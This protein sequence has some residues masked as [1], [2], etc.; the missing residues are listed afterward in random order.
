MVA[1]PNG[2]DKLE[3]VKCCYL[4]TVTSRG[5]F[6]FG[7]LDFQCWHVSVPYAF[8]FTG[9]VVYASVLTEIQYE[10]VGIYALYLWRSSF[11]YRSPIFATAIFIITNI[12]FGWI[13]SYPKTRCRINLTDH[14][15]HFSRTC[16]VR[17]SY[18]PVF[19]PSCLTSVAFSAI[20]EIYN[21]KSF[22]GTLFLFSRRLDF[23]CQ[24]HSYSSSIINYISIILTV[25]SV[26]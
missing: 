15:W 6:Q 12:S 25:Y 20:Y 11:S 23:P 18:S 8:R 5:N 21:V 2:S 24:Y 4:S 14:N 19:R 3:L 7:I 17:S 10:F 16:H 1:A 22:T 26:A 9:R 13:L